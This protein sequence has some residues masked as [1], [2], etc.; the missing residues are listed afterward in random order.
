MKQENTIF[1]SSF[2]KSGVLKNFLPLCLS[3]NEHVRGIAGS[4]GIS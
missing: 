1:L 4:V 2:Y 3:H